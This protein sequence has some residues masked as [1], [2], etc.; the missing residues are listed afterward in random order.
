MAFER[1]A[2][3]MDSHQRAY[4][5]ELWKKAV[6]LELIDHHTGKFKAL[7]LETGR[8]AETNTLSRAIIMVNRTS[9]KDRS[10]SRA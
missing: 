2:E 6:D 10:N 9:E 7:L 5:G 4:Y 8:E 3:H 1:L